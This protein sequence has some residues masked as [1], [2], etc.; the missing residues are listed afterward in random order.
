[1]KAGRLV[2]LLAVV[3]VMVSACGGAG[4]GGSGSSEQTT[5]LRT[6]AA[7]SS[8]TTAPVPSS[9]S[10]TATAPPAPTLYEPPPTEPEGE[11]KATA[12][13]FVETLG[14]FGPGGGAVEAAANR[15]EAA[16]FD[17]GLA[18]QALGIISGA[19]SSS[20]E[21]V[22]PQL[23]GLTGSEASVMVIVS[24]ERR[25]AGG[26]VESVSR[27]VDVRLRR[28]GTWTVTAVASDGGGAPAGAVPG[29]VAEQVLASD[30]LTMSDSARWD[31][32]AGRIDPR[33]LG[34]VLD[35]SAV[36]PLSITVFATGHPLN[37]FG[38]AS[39]SNHTRGRGVDIWGVGGAPVLGAG[40]GSPARAVADAALAAGVTELGSPWDLDGP[41]GPSFTN[42]LH[43]DHLHFAYDQ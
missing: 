28:G 3:S 38:E 37:V 10:T 14:T 34:L 5:R 41:G 36:S 18:A 27:T 4:D 9:T 23:G 1:M 2:P 16:G 8:T 19:D 25:A 39:V 29:T 35:L 17:R 32:A 30:R 7:Q 33:I 12:A 11:L 31:V 20:A 26:G 15:L 22:Y 24:L 40:P 6:T 21:I 43:A 42:A 13:R